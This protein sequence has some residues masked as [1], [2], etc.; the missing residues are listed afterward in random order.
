MTVVMTVLS[1]LT[2]RQSAIWKDSIT[3]WSYELDYLKRGSPSVIAETTALF[4]R[5]LAYYHGNEKEKALKDYTRII[6]IN[7]GFEKAYL[8]RGVIYGQLGDYDRAIADFSAAIR[9]NPREPDAYFNRALAYKMKGEMEMAA[10]DFR[11]AGE[12]KKGTDGKGP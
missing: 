7:P 9:I 1:L 2:V 8:N 11:Y 4:N 10:R 5:A 3:L 12:L 6:E